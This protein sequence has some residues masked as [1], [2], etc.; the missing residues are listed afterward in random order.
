MRKSK[1]KKG[2]VYCYENLI[3]TIWMKC[4][5][6]IIIDEIKAGQSVSQLA[7]EERKKKKRNRERWSIVYCELNYYIINFFFF[8][9]QTLFYF[10]L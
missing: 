9:K 10:L 2:C 6:N 5:Y 8:V 1:I 3:K 7:W 4:Q